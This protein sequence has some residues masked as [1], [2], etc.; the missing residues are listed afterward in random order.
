MWRSNV[1]GPVSPDTAAVRSIAVLPLR[2]SGDSADAYYA[3]GIGEQVSSAL[4]RVP[5][6]T[7]RSWETVLEAVKA[8]RNPAVLGPRLHVDYVLDGSFQRAGRRTRVSIQ[9]VRVADGAVIWSQPYD[10]EGA[11]IFAIQ[12]SVARGVA[13]EM[14]L[15]LS[16]ESQRALAHRT[17]RNPEAYNEYLRGRHFQWQLTA[18]SLDR[19]I[20]HYQAAIALDSGYADAWQGLVEASALRDEGGPGRRGLPVNALIDR[21][22]A[23]DS[24]NGAAHAFRAERQWTAFDFAAATRSYELA[25]LY[26]PGIA[27]TFVM[28]GQYLNI[29][30]RHQEALSALRRA[31]TL[32]PTSAFVV[33]N[34]ALRYQMLRRYDSAEVVARRAIALAPGNWVA[35][36][37][38][39]FALV[40]RGDATGGLTAMQEAQRLVGG[41]PNLVGFVGWALGR[42]GRREEALRLIGPNTDDFD[43]V[44]VLTGLGD[45]TGLLD[46]LAVA[47]PWALFF[48]RDSLFVGP[49]INSPRYQEL[50][51][52]F[53]YP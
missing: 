47:S 44:A 20:E 22:L 7:V 49:I 36:S 4:V 25:I 31:E 2:N 8:S 26:N 35:Q 6:V 40:G 24:T 27:E 12:D 51:R 1:R 53:D 19:A 39:G 38:L 10:G 30:G 9:L 23:L 28:Y 3:E 21:V 41:L 45:T 11:D 48:F 32:N 16:P 46:A 18:P 37:A 17:T 50:L 42:A 15:R 43:R 13:S 29:T 33:A 52:R 34:L 14:S 5:G